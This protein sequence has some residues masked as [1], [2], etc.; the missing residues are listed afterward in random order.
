MGNEEYNTGFS[1]QE[2]RRDTLK[3]YQALGVSGSDAVY[4]GFVAPLSSFSPAPTTWPTSTAGWVKIDYDSTQIANRYNY[5]ESQSRG[6][7][8]VSLGFLNLVGTG[9]DRGKTEHRVNTVNKLS[10]SYD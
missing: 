1:R 9:A 2:R 7:G 4:G 5:Q 3:T 8:G 10:Y 6:F